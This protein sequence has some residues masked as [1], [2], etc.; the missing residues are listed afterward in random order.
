MKGKQ[1]FL[2][3]IHIQ[4]VLDHSISLLVVWLKTQLLYVNE[5]SYLPLFLSQSRIEVHYL[6]IVRSNFSI[7]LHLVHSSHQF[8][9]VISPWKKK[10][11]RICL[12]LISQFSSDIYITTRI[13]I[14]KTFASFENKTMVTY[15]EYF[16]LKSV[17][18]DHLFF[19]PEVTSYNLEVWLFIIQ[20]LTWKEK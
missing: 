18:K 5:H 14:Y 19:V 17:L 9:Q 16:K 13:S 12:Y 7:H 4:N 20:Y 3:H 11:K 15:K 2:Y 1:L 10:K 8:I 6:Y